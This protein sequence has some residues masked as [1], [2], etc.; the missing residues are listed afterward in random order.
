MHGGADEPENGVPRRYAKLIVGPSAICNRHALRPSATPHRM[1]LLLT[2]SSVLEAVPT[3]GI[4]VL[5]WQRRE[6]VDHLTYRF[7]VFDRS[8]KGLAG[9]SW[10]GQRLL[11]V[12]EA[13][14]L[15]LN[16]QP[17][18]LLASRSFAFLNDCHHAVASADD[19][20]VCNTGLDCVEQFDCNWNHR[21]THFLLRSFGWRP[22]HLGQLAWLDAKKSYGRMRGW[23][24]NYPHPTYR[25]P[26]RNVRKYLRP[27]GFRNSGA[28]LRSYDFRPHALHPNHA[29]VVGD[30]VWVTLWHTGQLISLRTG[31]VLL[32]GLGW[33]HDGLIAGHQFFLTDCRANRVLAYA[34]DPAA[35]RLGPKLAERVVTQRWREGFVRGVA[36]IGDSVFVGLTA[37]RG[38]EREAD[39][40]LRIRRLDRQT[41]ETLEEW[42]APPELGL[43]V[44]SILP[45]EPPVE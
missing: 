17:L 31:R 15:E 1:K 12:S 35:R 26:L 4:A 21:Q 24:Y 43:G 41:L 38:Y 37:N 16:A 18:R 22:R 29:A 9:C 5:D 40:R 19:I 3:G 42:S 6:I 25:P 2:L 13:E 28:D 33:P 10:W 20:W 23:V 32:D 7:Q 11:A 39:R 30:D 36:V 14:I 44:Y 34:Y 8:N 45:A 27:P